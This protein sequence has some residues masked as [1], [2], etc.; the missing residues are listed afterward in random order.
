M[1]RGMSWLLLCAAAAALSILTWPLSRD[2]LD[3][4]PSLIA[5]Q[6]WRA[7]TAD[8]PTIRA[9]WACTHAQ[10]SSTGAA[11]SACPAPSPHPWQAA[12]NVVASHS[13]TR[14]GAM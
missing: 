7:L 9:Q 5:T 3:W 14:S 11:A 4:Q 8:T 6:P 1:T 2:T 13:S 12:G 10:Q